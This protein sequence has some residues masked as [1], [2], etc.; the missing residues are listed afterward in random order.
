M[1]RLPLTMASKAMLWEVMGRTVSGALETQGDRE[2]FH[3]LFP[4]AWRPPGG[5]WARPSGLSRLFCG[6]FVLRCNSHTIKSAHLWYTFKRLQPVP[7][8]V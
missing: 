1:V 8:A 5:S 3:L 7:R 4:Q 6:T 2:V